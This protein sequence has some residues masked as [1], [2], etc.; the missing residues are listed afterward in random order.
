MN[1]SAVGAVGSIQVVIFTIAKIKHS[2]DILDT[3]CRGKGH[4][5]YR[6]LYPDEA[7][8]VGEDPYEEPKQNDQ[9]RG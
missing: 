1:L 8:A 3:C 2:E 5:P 4:I 9:Q 6:Q 7:R